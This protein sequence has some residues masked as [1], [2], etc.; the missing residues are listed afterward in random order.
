MAAMEREVARLSQEQEE[1]H[2]I[3]VPC[4]AASGE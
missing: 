1:V 2:Y 4:S 3:Q